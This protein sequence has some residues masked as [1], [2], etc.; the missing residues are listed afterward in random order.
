MSTRYA[1]LLI[2]HPACTARAYR[3]RQI[4]CGQ[5]GSWA[6]E[7]LMVHIMLSGFLSCP[8]DGVDALAAG[9]NA[10]AAESRASSP[11]FGLS[12]E[13]VS[14]HPGKPGNLSLD[15][16]PQDSANP[17]RVIHSKIA[18][19]AGALADSVDEQGQAVEETGMFLPLMQFAGLPPDLFDDAV[20]FAKAVVEDLG[21]PSATT[22]WRLVLAR[23]QSQAAGDHWNQG[24]WATDVSWEL[25]A[26]YPL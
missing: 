9:L 6:A 17:L 19:L 11:E 23:F 7:M 24:G 14:L 22:A 20:V 18:G 8:D 25:A 3:A 12:H 2:P 16:T 4:I 5:Y 26:S 1:V 10:I 15:F 21:V 13:G